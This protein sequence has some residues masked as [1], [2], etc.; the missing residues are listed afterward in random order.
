M[1]KRK[2]HN[3]ETRKKKK[4]NQQKEVSINYSTFITWYFGVYL[5]NFFNPW[6]SQC[7]IF[8]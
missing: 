3:A 8:I 6:E 7:T 1:L 4:K 2:H 5:I